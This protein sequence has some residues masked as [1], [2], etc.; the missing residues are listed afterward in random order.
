MDNKNG[1]IIVSIQSQVFDGFCG[2]NV[3]TFVL[4]RRGHIPK[5]LNTV[6][7]YSKYKHI[8]AEI[9]NDTLKN[10]INEFC[11]DILFAD[12]SS[13]T[14]NHTT[15]VIT[16]TS[17]T[18][19]NQISFLTGYMKTYDCVDIVMNAIVE[20]KKK[21]KIENII[22][23]NE[24]IEKIQNKEKEQVELL[25]ENIINL[26]YFWIC[27]PVMG[28]NGRVYVDSDVVK[29]YTKATTYA[30]IITPN[31]F[32]LELLS[33]TKINN[34]KDVIKSIDQLL[35]NGSKIIIV[36]S[37]RYSFDASNLY[38]YVGFYNN[39]KKLICFKFKIPRC[40]IDICGTGDL[41]TSLLLSFILKQ[42][43]N[44]LK[45]I[46]KVL[47]I[48]QHVIKNSVGS[49]DLRIIENQDIIATDGLIGD[50]IKEEL[51]SI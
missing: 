25:I 14:N 5:I 4:R 49:M 11:K 23:N 35:N 22:T 33:N 6:Q 27:D 34:E 3:G 30:D 18:N 13:N 24:N 19:T 29:A 12:N 9:S 26:N 32:E 44:I 38:L 10:I 31:Q 17:T 50:L 43:G 40:D 42:K 20:L 47:N 37:V 8:G 41:F 21:K 51:V 16:A 46:S 2:N 28:D 48:M 1:E 45:I 39:N 15:T 7:Y 36:T